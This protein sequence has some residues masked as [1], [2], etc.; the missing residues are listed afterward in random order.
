M[1][2]ALNFKELATI[3][4]LISEAGARTSFVTGDGDY[5]SAV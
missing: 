3:D 2:W 4:N 5:A 1:I